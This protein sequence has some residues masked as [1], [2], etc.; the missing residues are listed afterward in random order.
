[1][2][3][4]FSSDHYLDF[5]THSLRREDRSDITEI[6]SLHLGKEK[7]H[8]LYTIAKHP[9]WATE[10][11]SIEEREILAKHLSDPKCLAMGEMGLDKLKGVSLTVQIDIFK[12]QL[13]LA[14]KLNKPVIIHCVRAYDAL[15]KV[16]KVFPK[17]K[18]W[19]VHGYSRNAILAQQ[20][21]KNGF[22]LSIMPKREITDKY[23]DLLRSLPKDYFF[24]ETDSMPDSDIVDIYEKVATIRGISI[25]QLKQQ[26]AK[27]AINFFFVE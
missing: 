20:L 14:Q 1:M 9:W 17:V 8:R 15:I 25:N 16:K 11:L 5:H 24:L 21:V 22:Y 19:C 26:L 18:K 12:S 23:A 13:K 2:Q 6:V 10:I 3:E 4:L 27:N 7:E